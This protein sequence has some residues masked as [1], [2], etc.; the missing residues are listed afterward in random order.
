MPIGLRTDF[1]A[2]KLRVAAKR[3]RDGGQARRLLLLSR[4]LN[5]GVGGGG[6]RSRRCPLTRTSAT[7][8]CAVPASFVIPTLKLVCTPFLKAYPRW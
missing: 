7:D 8:T 5:R 2:G 6:G 1:D 3:S 4:S